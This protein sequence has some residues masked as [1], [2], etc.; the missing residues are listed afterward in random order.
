MVMSKL[1]ELRAGIGLTFSFNRSATLRSKLLAVS[2][3]GNYCTVV[4]VD[5]DGN[6]VGPKLHQPSWLIWNSMFY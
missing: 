6:E 1:D 4:S 2:K 3:C 5:K